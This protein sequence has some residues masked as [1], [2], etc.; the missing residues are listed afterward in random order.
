MAV[1]QHVLID[2]GSHWSSTLVL[3]EAEL[4]LH[5][6]SEDLPVL[7]AYGW[8]GP[9]REHFERL[10]DRLRTRRD[11][12]QPPRVPSVP[13]P[14]RPGSSRPP[15][16]GSP[17]TGPA[18]ALESAREER[19]R[20]RAW[21]DRAFSILEAAELEHAAAGEALARIPPPGD[22]TTTLSAA[23]RVALDRCDALR[24]HL[25]PEAADA[26]FFAQGT[27]LATSLAVALE[28]SPVDPQDRADQLD[29][30]DGEVYLTIRGL[31][32]AGRRAF[33][34]LGDTSHGDRY[35]F[36]FLVTISRGEDVAPP[37]RTDSPRT[38]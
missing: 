12:W 35:T 15:P 16:G 7:R 3:A 13:S 17:Q 30:L 23:V 36:H 27:A 21:L 19:A 38:T 4:A 2:I 14:G 6:W 1:P 37:R 28:E 22:G 31:N 20:A 26:A 8:G 25:D 32:R 29:A 5:R 18:A 10:V 11:A 33:S 34:A 9:R 24:D